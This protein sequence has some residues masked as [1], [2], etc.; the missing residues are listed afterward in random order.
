LAFIS[1]GKII[2]LWTATCTVSFTTSLSNHLWVDETVFV[3]L[4]TLLKERWIIPFLWVHT[5]TLSS[6]PSFTKKR[7]PRFSS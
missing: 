2:K 4:I 3:W 1:S 7:C 6:K 5:W